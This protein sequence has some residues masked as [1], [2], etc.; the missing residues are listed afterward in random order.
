VGVTI[1]D[2]AT[3]GT[4]HDQDDFLTGY[5]ADAEA[6]VERREAESGQHA[7]EGLA[8]ILRHQSEAFGDTGRARQVFNDG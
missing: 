7:A 8:S 2:L 3:I 5:A 4:A 1:I 6:D